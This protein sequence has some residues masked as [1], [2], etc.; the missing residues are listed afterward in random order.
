MLRDNLQNE[1]L[2]HL[3]GI[4]VRLNGFLGAPSWPL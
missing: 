2:H 1:V 4:E 3:V